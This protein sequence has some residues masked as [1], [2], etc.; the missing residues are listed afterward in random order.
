MALG[1]VIK[2][3]QL[4]SKGENWGEIDVNRPELSKFLTVGEACVAIL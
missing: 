4:N 2:R 3:T 1:K